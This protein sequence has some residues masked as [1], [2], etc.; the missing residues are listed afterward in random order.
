MCH[1]YNLNSRRRIVKVKGPANFHR[2]DIV[3]AQTLA[4][5][6]DIRDAN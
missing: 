6:W 2:G 5:S 1:G 3:F 4:T